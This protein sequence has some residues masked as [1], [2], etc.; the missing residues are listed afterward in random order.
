[1]SDPVH[2]D[3]DHRRADVPPKMIAQ[4]RRL[5]YQCEVLGEG[6]VEIITEMVT[7]NRWQIVSM[8][9]RGVPDGVR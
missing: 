4:G 6:T 9:L 2:I 7:C 8:R 5:I 1:M 3:V